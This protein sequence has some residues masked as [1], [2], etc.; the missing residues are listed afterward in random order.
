MNCPRDW[1]E[2]IIRVQSLSDSGITAIP[3]RYVK[4]P[5]ARPSFDS[6]THSDANIPIIDLG[7]LNGGDNLESITLNKVHDAC[8]EWGFFQVVNHGV[9]P[10]L[11]DRAREVWREFFHQPMEVKQVYGNSPN[12][13]E[14][15]GSRLGVDKGAILDWSDYYFLHYLPYSSRDYNKWPALPTSLR[16]V[17]DEYSKQVVRLGGVLL[18]A[19]SIN[20]GLK[21]KFLQNAFGGDDIGA[22][23]RVN[24]YPKCP[25]P[26]LTL[27][28]SPHSD[29]GG[30]T[31]LLPDR[32]V[33]G[34]QVRKN[35]GW[36]TVK[37]APHAFIVNI[38]DQ[39]QVMSNAIYKSVEHQVIV[40]SNQERLSLAYF[41]NP[42]SDLLIQPATELV[43]L[44]RPPLYSAM[45][46]DEYRLYIRTKGPR[47]KS[48]LGESLKSPND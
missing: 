44:D 36:I 7:G 29:P 39:I 28:L 12:T 10:D 17:I 20:L 18:K 9:S 40:N 5:S 26:D 38:G 33:S 16:E 25:Q 11:M 21:E 42:K 8:L 46:F 4:A 1:P 3:D 27:G 31:F 23:L 43:T 14:G 45:T 34:L 48:Q 2:P 24:F 22:C 41:Y 19:L 35:D 6:T 13:Y 15:Y 37:P 32:N 47:G 30:M